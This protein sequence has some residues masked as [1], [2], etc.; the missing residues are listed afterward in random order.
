MAAHI[1]ISNHVAL[2]SVSGAPDTSLILPNPADTG[3]RLPTLAGSPQSTP[4]P[5]GAL[6]VPGDPQARQF[7]DMALQN[8]M[9]IGY[10]V[11]L[12]NFSPSAE[13]QRLTQWLGVASGCLST[14][15][16]GSGETYLNSYVAFL[17]SQTHYGVKVG[18]GTRSPGGE[19]RVPY[20]DPTP[21][22][23]S[24]PR[25]DVGDT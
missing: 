25:P 5:M 8:S 21:S 19:P 23:A 22:I 11:G 17:L 3:L 16:Y 20:S 4:A 7:G 18:G 9:A 15:S 14:F 12:Q 10:Q 24:P 6:V 13:G 1:P 2:T